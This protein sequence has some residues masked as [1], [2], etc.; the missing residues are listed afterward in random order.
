MDRWILSELHSLITKVDA[1]YANYEP[2]KAARAISEFVQEK[3][4]NWYVR[5]NRRRFWKGSYGQDKIAA[6]QTLFESLLTVAKLAAP[7]AP[8]YSDR[9]YQDL[10]ED[11]A[12]EN[13]ASVHLSEFPT[14]DPEAIDT[15]SLIHI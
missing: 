8:F 15:L 5:L 2:T 3:L 13:Y 14:P 7:I 4:S 12:V 10:I 6:Y 1:D 11:T 9:L